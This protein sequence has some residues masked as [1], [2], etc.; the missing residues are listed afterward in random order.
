MSLRFPTGPQYFSQFVRLL[1]Y[2][3]PILKNYIRNEDAMLDCLQAIEVT[4]QG[5]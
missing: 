2:F 1:S 5:H 3:A 4:A